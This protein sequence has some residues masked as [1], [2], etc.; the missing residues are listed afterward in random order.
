M[1]IRDIAISFGY[2][3]DKQSE[4]KVE[5]SVNQIK[6]MATNVLSTIGLGFSLVKLNKLTEEF[7]VINDRIKYATSGLKDQNAVQQKIL[8]AANDS[9]TAYSAMATSVAG[10]LNTHNKLFSSVEGATNYATLMYKAF[11]ASGKTD[12]EIQSL[13]SSLTSAYITGKVSAGQFSTLMN[14]MP[15]SVTYL[16]KTL[17]ITE[18]QVKALGMAGALT[19]KQLYGAVMANANDIDNGFENVTLTISDALRRVRNQFGLWLAQFDKALGLTQS[20]AKSVIRV[21]NHVIGALSKVTAYL[22]RLAKRLGGTDRLLKLIAVTVGSFLVVAKAGSIVKFVKSIGQLINAASV[23]II[24]ISALVL[25]LALIVEDFI[26]FLKGNDN[27]L[28]KLLKDAG[29]DTD[30]A[31]KD[32]ISAIGK[33]KS[34][35][36]DTISDIAPMLKDLAATLIPTLTEATKQFGPVL[37]DVIKTA[38][39]AILELSKSFVSA[40]GEFIKTVLPTLIVLLKSV[41]GAI[42][43]LAKSIMPV[44]ARLIQELLPVITDMIDTALPALVRLLDAILPSVAKII[45]S[46]LPAIIQLVDSLLPMLMNLVSLLTPILDS[47]LSLIGPLVG[48]LADALKPILQVVGELLAPLTELL[49]NILKPIIKF[50]SLMLE[51]QLRLLNATLKPIINALQK[52]FSAISPIMKALTILHGTIL[53]PIYDIMQAIVGMLTGGMSDALDDFGAEISYV[54]DKIDSVLGGIGKAIGSAASFIG[55]AASSAV[56]WASDAAGKVGGSIKSGWNKFTGWL[57]FA[58]GGYVEPNKPRHIV[59]G[60]NKTEGEIISPVSK[61]RS[62]VLSALSMFADANMPTK[63]ASILNQET[64][65]RTITQNVNISNTFSGGTAET[66]RKIARA[67]SKSADDATTILARGLAYAR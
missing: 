16:S 11:R 37:M 66:Q 17:G 30:K 20:I 40:L 64:N 6:N 58:E 31:R 61:M 22:D 62:A 29:A 34:F 38:L 44:I 51:V 63:A 65:N 57:G 59:V 49:E 7:T 53:K 32:I 5:A 14:Q 47:V 21:S 15:R 26:Q 43:A 33:I 28:E 12:A 46:I 41:A 56:N 10:L 18:Q 8:A 2:E 67:M 23:K 52:V 25:A 24:A 45:E 3:V 27:I 50:A 35:I 60:D 42:A 55:D 19:A 9:R 39:P 13:S 4:K 48:L 36:K 54:L 1:T